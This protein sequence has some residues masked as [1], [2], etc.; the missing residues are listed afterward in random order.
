MKISICILATLLTITLCYSCK[1]ND[2]NQKFEND[3]KT[4]IHT[5]EMFKQSA[6]ESHALA[7]NA[8]SFVSKYA[9]NKDSIMAFYPRY[10]KEN[11]AMIEK[12]NDIIK[13][14]KKVSDEYLDDIHPDFK[15]MY[16]EKFV[17]MLKMTYDIGLRTIKSDF[18][19]EAEMNEMDTKYGELMS[20]YFVYLASIQKDIEK[21]PNLK[22][23]FI[24]FLSDTSR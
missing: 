9:D 22:K 10:K 15:K 19:N 23:A 3:E 4:F 7:S 1:R 8:K 14:S 16:Y 2:T 24:D 18:K 11:Y 13:E 6:T 20:S 21:H 17:A 12:Y 5:L